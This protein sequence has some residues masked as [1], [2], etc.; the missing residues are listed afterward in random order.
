[1]EIESF[2]SGSGEKIR[3]DDVLGH[4]LL[5]WAIQYIPHSP[6]KFTTVGKPSDVI[7]VDAV[8]LTSGVVGK[9]SWWRQSR[10]IRDLK[11]KI[12][13]PNPILVVIQRDIASQGAQAPYDMV[14]MSADPAAVQT[15]NAWFQANPDFEVSVE[16]VYNPNLQPQV[17]TRPDQGP[18]PAWATAP[19]Y[20]Q[21]L[22]S[23]QGQPAWMP[24]QE[25]WPGQ[26][27]SPQTVTPQPQYQPPA[28]AR[29]MTQAERM[30]EQQQYGY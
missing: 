27:N 13:K 29:P 25:Y 2:N 30:A 8:D 12:G 24:A 9:R 28:P 26:S 10:L 17:E 16:E 19:Q 15:A 1:M 6:T 23:Q 21:P 4:L 5:V 18:P 14:S 7:V 22:P 20:Q 11:P 3:P